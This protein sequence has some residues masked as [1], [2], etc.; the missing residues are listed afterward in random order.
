[1]HCADYELF[2]LISTG[3]TLSTHKNFFFSSILT[4]H[5]TREIVRTMTSRM[6]EVIKILRILPPSML[7]V[8]RS[9]PAHK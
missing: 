4:K 9:E 1:M 6:D 2:A 7:V 3:R 5:D 8:F